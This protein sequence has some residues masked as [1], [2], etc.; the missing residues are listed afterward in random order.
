MCDANLT[1]TPRRM[2][3]VLC[4]G[5][6]RRQIRHRSPGSHDAGTVGGG[7]RR[8]QDPFVSVSFS[9]KIPLYKTNFEHRVTEMCICVFSFGLIQIELGIGLSGNR[10]TD[11]LTGIKAERITATG[12][13]S[14][15][16]RN[17]GQS[18]ESHN[19]TR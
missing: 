15:T 10:S 12:R 19:R 18:V 6:R 16:S 5:T 13:R 17:S 11:L 14:A 2:S 9:L 1:Q 8:Q 3:P 4:G 7:R